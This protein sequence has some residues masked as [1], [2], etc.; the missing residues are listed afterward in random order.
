MARLSKQRRQQLA[1][2]RSGAAPR[3]AARASTHQRP[4]QAA[5]APA[6]WRAPWAWGS[7][8]TAVVVAVLVVFVVIGQSAAKASP[9]ALAPASLV[10]AVTGLSPSTLATV[11]AGGI[12]DPLQKLP[13]STAALKSSGKPEV[14]MFSE[15]S[16][17]YCAFE[18]WSLVV[19][20]SRFGTFTNLH[21]TTS[22]SSDYFPDTASFSFYGSSYSS[23]HLAFQGLETADRVGNPLQTPTAAEESVLTTYDAPPYVSQS[24]DPLPFLD[25]GGRYYASGDPPVKYTVSGQSITAAPELLEGLTAEQ[26]AESL[27]DTSNYQSQAILGNANWVTAALCGLTDNQPGSVCSTSTITLLEGQLG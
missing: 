17:P 2:S 7:G 6:W 20:L 13:A 8:A 14:M 3:P 22:S 27:A 25:L 16:C 1:A 9:D 23:S 21:L 4:R 15:D 26:I 11:G 12:A 10:S 24:G 19:A 18:R 5:P